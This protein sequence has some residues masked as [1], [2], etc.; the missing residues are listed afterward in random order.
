[1]RIASLKTVTCAAA[2]FVGVSASPIVA[3]QS[4]PRD[5]RSAAT[6]RPEPQ[7]QRP[8]LGP[9]EEELEGTLEVLIEDHARGTVVHHFLDTGRGKVRLLEAL[10]ESDLK[11]MISGQRVRARGRRSQDGGSLELRPGG[12]SGGDSSVT[13]T[14]LAVNNTFGQQRVLVIMVNFQDNQAQSTNYSEAYQTTFNG[15]NS[16]FQE[17][18]YGQTYLT[19]DVVGTYTLPMSSGVCD[20]NQVASLADQA[21]S[22]AG[23]NVN[24]YARRVYAFPN[25]ACGWWGLATVGGNPSRA[26]I[27]GS[28]QL[29]V[30]AHE[31]GHNFGDWHSNSQPCQNGACSTSEYG[32]DRDMMGLSGTGHFNAY[33][34]E[35]LGWLNYGA[36]PA[37][38]TIT[39]PGTYFVSALQ[40]STAGPKA[41]KVLQGS[42][43]YYYVEAR[44]QVGFDAPYYPGVLIHTGN[45]SNGNSSFQ[46][47]MDP[48][49]GT[50]DAM[51][52]PGQS[53]TET[54]RN[55]TFRTVSV[56][57]T[58]AWVAIDMPAAP[59]TM[60][61]PNVTLSP[62]GTVSATA[63][64]AKSFTMTVKNNDDSGCPAAVFEPQMSMPGDW[65]W[66]TSYQSITLNG[67]AQTQVPFSVTPA[68]TASGSYVV[69][70]ASTRTNSGGPSNSTSVTMAVTVPSP[71]PT[72]TPAPPP[73]TAPADVALSLVASMSSPQFTLSATVRNNGSLA[74]GVTVKFTVKDPRGAEQTYTATTNSMGVATVK[75][76]LKPKDPRGAYVASATATM[77]V[78]TSTG[79]AGFIY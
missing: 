64:A 25:N 38:Q 16:F 45:E 79:S 20:V 15:A 57:A 5:A 46:L 31:M 27:N 42:G 44:A 55:I 76:R 24:N 51:L 77:G 65:S 8:A 10:G 35:R 17:N 54:V 71:T 6:A 37:I 56:D 2:L 60:R 40:G 59:C 32:D 62:S 47:D 22:N 34:K 33:Q 69:T 50:F 21:A 14:A 70:A 49:S 13:T 19:G 53:F 72:P 63:G 52:D 7:S 4:G 58:G 66:T 74:S 1:M 26:W 36:S 11:G 18:S 29:K 73:P 30:V 61:A 23:V 3:R 39:G 9:G 12:S 75:G 78:S 67:G 43:T 68:A 28:Y 41:L 48:Y